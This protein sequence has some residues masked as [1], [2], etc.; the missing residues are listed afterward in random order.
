MSTTFTVDESATKGVYHLAVEVEGSDSVSLIRCEDM[1]EVLQ[2][3]EENLT[4]D[5]RQGWH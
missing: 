4:N 3:I 5:L 1:D 2:Y